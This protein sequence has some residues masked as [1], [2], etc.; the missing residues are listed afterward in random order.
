[1]KATRNFFNVLIACMACVTLAMFSSCDD[2][3][4]LILTNCPMP[5]N[6]SSS[7][8]IRTRILCTSFKTKM[9]D[10]RIMTLF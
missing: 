1:M 8:I 6:S 7:V 3:K 4:T 10:A 2:E 9:T 5:R